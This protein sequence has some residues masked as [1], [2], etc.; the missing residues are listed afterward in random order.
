MPFSRQ[1]AF[2]L[3]QSRYTG[4]GDPAFRL[5]TTA[6]R[7]AGS[8]ESRGR[9]QTSSSVT[10]PP[11][12][13]CAEQGKCFES[14]LSTPASGRNEA[15]RRCITCSAPLRG[16]AGYV[17]NTCP[18]GAPSAELGSVVFAS[19]CITLAAP[20]HSTRLRNSVCPAPAPLQGRPLFRSTRRACQFPAH[21]NRDPL[22]Q[23]RGRARP[24][25]RKEEGFYS[26]YFIVP[27]KGGGLRPILDLRVFNRAL[28][29]LPFKML[30]QRNI[31]AGVQHLDW[32]A[33]VDLKDAYFHVSILPGHR[34]FLRFAFDGQS[35]Q[36]K[37]LPFGLSLSPRVFTKV[38]EA[39]LAPLRVAGIRI[40]NYLDDWLILAHSRELL[41]THSDQVLRHLSRLGLQVN[42]EK[43]KLT[44][45]QSISFLGLELDSVSMT[46]RLTSERAQSV[47][48]CL[49]SFKPGTVVPLKLFQRLLGHMA[50]SA[51]VAPLGL[52]HMRPLQHWFQTLVPRQAWHHG[53]HR[54]RITPACLKTLRPWTD[55]CFLRAGVPVQQVS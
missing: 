18:F 5:P 24:S 8:D 40:L 46:A 15:T 42:W 34:P 49:A 39:A 50:S 4:R 25:N 44:P 7:P 48:D 52:M 13:G 20:D 12:A 27:K 47:L 9:Q 32:F 33:A 55:L 31:L 26:P 54:V 11:P 45:V 19:Q 35:F 37:V 51:V 53:T 16:P 21:G 1:S 30:T 14:I 23:G 6:P 29:K 28:L 41:C 38:A 22:S 43:S 36:Y 10:N 17:Q 3:R 2:R